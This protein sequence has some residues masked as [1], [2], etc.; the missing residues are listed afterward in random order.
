MTKKKKVELETRL[1]TRLKDLFSHHELLRNMITKELK[2]KYKSSVLGFLWSFIN[3][4]VML[5]VFSI[6]FSIFTRGGDIQWYAVYLMSALLP[7]NF[8]VGSLMQA[9]SSVVANAGLV[10]KIYF[11]REILPI[12]AVGAN[13]VHFLLQ[14]AVF[15]VFLLI[16]G[17]HFSILVLLFPLVTLL[18]CTFLLG[19]AFF[20]SAADVYLRDTQHFVEVLTMAWFWITPIVYPISLVRDAFPDMLKFYLANPMANIALIWQ[21]IIYNPKHYAPHAAYIS[22]WGILGTVLVSIALLIGGYIFF[23]RKE[24]GFAQQI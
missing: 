1:S 23:V 19:L 21:Y 7:W 24:R 9:T 3:P 6:V 22:R 13:L 16:I 17:W 18:E 5:I 12:S 14:S 4:L 8:F 20:L 15:F 2:V 11:P 10:K